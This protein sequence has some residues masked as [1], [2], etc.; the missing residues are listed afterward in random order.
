MRNVKHPAFVSCL[1]NSPEF[2]D[3]ADA[4][5]KIKE[6]LDALSDTMVQ[7]SS[8]WS[9]D[10]PGRDLVRLQKKLVDIS[11]SILT[12]GNHSCSV[13]IPLMHMPLLQKMT[14]KKKRCGRCPL[15][16][17][18]NHLILTILLG[19]CRNQKELSQ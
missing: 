10:N 7:L 17:D 1:S 4:G 15:R 5:M 2:L 12:H 8:C 16:G 19:K 9:V 11:A 6:N 13:T 18:V 14:W 3:C